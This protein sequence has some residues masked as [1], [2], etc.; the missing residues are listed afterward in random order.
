MALT[1]RYVDGWEKLP[2]GYSHK[3]VV[4]VQVDPADRVYILTRFDPQVLVFESDGRF[5]ASFAQGTFTPRT[6]GLTI[7]PDGSLFCV[8]DGDHTV[9]R[10]SPDGKLLM[11]IGTPGSASDTGYTG[12]IESITRAAGPF[13][14]CTNIAV[15]PS[16]ELYVSDGYGNARVHRFTA[17]GKLIQSWGEPG[18]G[19]GQ[20][21]LPHGVAIESNGN[22]WVADRENDRIQIFTADG[23]YLREWTQVQRPTQVRIQNGRV[24]VSELWWRVGQKSM[25][26]GPITADQF[27]RISIFDMQGKLLGRIEGGPDPARKD[28]LV[29]PHDV[30]VDSKGAIYV[31]EVTQTFGVKSGAVPEGTHSFQKFEP[32]G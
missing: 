3:D 14:R 32:A 17:A 2:S 30:A 24:Y 7:A 19:P 20:F 8:D 12:T 6:H 15:A 26:K 23:K 16:G 28:G 4:G 9:R 5:V 31:G 27:G 1:Y 21:N 18:A 13:N 25:R 29:A 22:V 11:M 10:L